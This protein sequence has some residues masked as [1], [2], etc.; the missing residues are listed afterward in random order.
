MFTIYNISPLKKM[1]VTVF[2]ISFYTNFILTWCFLS[3]RAKVFCLDDKNI[4]LKNLDKNYR[5]KNNILISNRIIWARDKLI[6]TFCTKYLVLS[7]CLEYYA[8]AKD[9]KGACFLAVCRGKVAEGLDFADDNGRACII[10]GL[11]YPPLKDARYANCVLYNFLF[12][13][14]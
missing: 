5:T 12:H 13:L 4:P 7:V 3:L 6:I 9:K 14:N 8:A 1:K 11:P 2:F 10:T